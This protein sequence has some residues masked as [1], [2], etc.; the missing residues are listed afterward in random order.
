MCLS[1]C[2]LEATL[3]RGY[4]YFPFLQME[5][6]R[7]R[8]GRSFI[9]VV[10]QVGGRAGGLS[11]GVSLCPLPLSI[12]RIPSPSLGAGPGSRE[13]ARGRDSQE[14]KL[15]ELVGEGWSAWEWPAVRAWATGPSVCGMPGE[16]GQLGRYRLC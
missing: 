8:D 2:M 1:L 4:N 10:Q 6:L 7:L 12:W 3:S 16:G 14:F 9:K 13:E 15:V 11:P 5:K